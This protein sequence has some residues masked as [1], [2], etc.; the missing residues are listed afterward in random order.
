MG[1]VP[2]ML[3]AVAAAREAFKR[4]VPDRLEQQGH[5]SPSQVSARTRL[6][7]NS[8]AS[9]SITAEA[10]PA[11]LVLIGGLDGFPAA[12]EL[13]GPANTPSRAN[14]ICS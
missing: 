10:R 5:S 2:V 8:E 1:G 9:V 11:A 13:N 14:S 6:L 4:I 7:S 3:L 12:A